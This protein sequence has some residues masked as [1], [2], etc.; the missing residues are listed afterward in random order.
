MDRRRPCGCLQCVSAAS[1]ESGTSL[2]RRA[3][4]RGCDDAH[5]LHHR[6]RMPGETRLPRF[7]PGAPPIWPSPSQQAR[8][9]IPSNAPAPSMADPAAA[10]SSMSCSRVCVG[11][12]L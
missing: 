3:R 8:S 1:E 9:S 10:H 7:S 4:R 2:R 11:A 12:P 5:Q 6:Q